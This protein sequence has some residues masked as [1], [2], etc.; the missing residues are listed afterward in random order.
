MAE[1]Y[2]A[3]ETVCAVA[4][5]YGLSPQQLFTWRRAARRPMGHLPNETGIVQLWITTESGKQ[6]HDHTAMAADGAFGN[7]PVPSQPGLECKDLVVMG[8]RRILPQRR[9]HPAFHQKAHEPPRSVHVFGG[10]IIGS[11]DAGTAA[12]MPRK[13]ANDI[14]INFSDADLRAAQPLTEMTR[15]VLVA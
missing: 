11:A 4:R 15:R 6:P 1:S 3:G 9:H 13:A 7:P 8:A 12:S 14:V 10:K 2:E 5:R